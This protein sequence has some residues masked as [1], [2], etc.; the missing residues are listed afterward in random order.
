VH[1]VFREEKLC[2][3][4]GELRLLSEPAWGRLSA[5][6]TAREAGR[7]VL[8]GLEGQFLFYAF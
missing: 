8:S 3:T 6:L 7:H 2:G 5:L 4:L 1:F